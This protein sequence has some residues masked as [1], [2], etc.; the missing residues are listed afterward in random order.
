M[1]DEIEEKDVHI[2]CDKVL[3]VDYSSAIMEKYESNSES[4]PIFDVDKWVELS[5]GLNKGS[6]YGFEYYKIG[7]S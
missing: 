3:K 2:A 4:H 7:K 5:S 1:W 6:V